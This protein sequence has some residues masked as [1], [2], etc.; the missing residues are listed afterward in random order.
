LAAGGL[1]QETGVVVR[2]ALQ[3]DD[4]AIGWNGVQKDRKACARFMRIGRAYPRPDGFFR[5][6]RAFD[7]VSDEDGVVN[8]MSK[9]DD[10]ARTRQACPAKVSYWAASQPQKG[11]LAFRASSMRAKF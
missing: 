11:S 9:R 3:E 5:A 7:R 6:G 2:I 1:A 4:A 10:P 8:H